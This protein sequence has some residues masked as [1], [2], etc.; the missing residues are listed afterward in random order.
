[1]GSAGNTGGANGDQDDLPLGS[2]DDLSDPEPVTS[3]LYPA[4]AGKR[5][6]AGSGEWLRPS[7]ALRLWRIGGAASALLLASFLLVQTLGPSLWTRLFPP[8]A[9]PTPYQAAPV[10]VDANGLSCVH[11]LSWSP[12]S[13]QFALLGQQQGFGCIPKALSTTPSG[14][15]EIVALYDGHTGQLLHRITLDAP[16][17][18]ALDLAQIPQGSSSTPSP[19][20]TSTPTDK[21]YTPVL[22]SMVFYDSLRWS[23]N[24]K[25]LAVLFTVEIPGGGLRSRVGLLLLDA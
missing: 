23:P 11:D 19:S 16:I 24:G 3:P 15:G 14:N 8:P 13:Q 6:I 20:A 18:R 4:S 21:Q 9:T 22:S 17:S 2:D 7:R 12:S 10:R 5:A 25:M 1:M